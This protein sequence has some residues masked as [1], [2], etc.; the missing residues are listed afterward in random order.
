MSW[1]YPWHKA[2]CASLSLHQ[3]ITISCSC[4]EFVLKDAAAVQKLLSEMD[5]KIG[6]AQSSTDHVCATALSDSIT[7]ILRRARK[8]W[9]RCRR[10]TAMLWASL[11]I[12]WPC[13]FVLL[14][15]LRPC[16]NGSNGRQDPQVN[17]L[18]SWFLGNKLD[19]TLTQTLPKAQNIAD[20]MHIEVSCLLRSLCCK[21]TCTALMAVAGAGKIDGS[22]A[23]SCS[24]AAEARQTQRPSADGLLCA[25]GATTS[26]TVIIIFTT[27]ARFA[28]DICGR[29]MK[30]IRKNLCEPCCSRFWAACWCSTRA[31][32][33]ADIAWSSTT[34]SRPWF[35][36]FPRAMTAIYYCDF[37][38]A[39]R[40]SRFS[41]C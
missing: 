38:D 15:V 17:R 32:M 28:A 23:W 30:R 4:S 10:R 9:R 5:R 12:L 11:A 18:A 24:A 31:T 39:I 7:I 2:T 29:R 3:H 21:G 13:P 8:L 6:A 34:A 19:I 14:I 20:T 37:G 40:W 33:H 25:S 26:C 1:R 16:L 41:V 35:A 36:V 22:H 27:R